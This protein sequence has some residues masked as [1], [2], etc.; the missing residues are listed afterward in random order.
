MAKA[1]NESLAIAIDRLADLLP[2][3]H[4]LASLGSTGGADLLVT[5]AEEI[6]K[7]R[8]KVAKLKGELNAIK[9]TWIEDKK[10]GG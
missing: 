1:T 3:G 2:N 4:L 9:D 7:L 5:A 8:A 6:L 10:I